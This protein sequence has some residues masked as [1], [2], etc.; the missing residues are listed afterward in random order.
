MRLATGLLAVGDIDDVKYVFMRD[1]V[2]FLNKNL[3]SEALK[4]DPF[5]NIMRLM[6][7]SD[8]EIYVHDEALEV[9]G[10]ELLDLIKN[11]NLQ[12]INYEQISEL[13]TKADMSFKY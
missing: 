7:L 12:V 6:E 5:E 10:M 13:I 3:E 11:D 4:V 1:A 9:A 2:Y 8:L